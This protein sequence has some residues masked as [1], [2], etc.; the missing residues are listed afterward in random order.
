MKLL[1]KFLFF[2]SPLYYIVSFIRNLLYDTSLFKSTK[3]NL[4]VIGIGNLAIGGTGKSPMIEYLI[5]LLSQEFNIATLSRG[6]G[7]KTNTFK[8]ATKDSTHFDIGDEPLQFYNKHDNLIVSVDNNRVNGIQSLLQISNPPDVILLDD[9]YQHRKLIPGLSILLSD[10]SNLYYDDYI[11]PFGDLREPR[12]SSN[13]ADIVI[14]TK[15]PNNLSSSKK[16]EIKSKLQ[17]KVSQKLFFSSINYSETVIIGNKKV[18]FIN[19]ITQKFTL[20]TGLANSNHLVNY[21]SENKC[22]FNHLK[23][24]DHY[25]YKPKDLDNVDFNVNILTTEKDYAKL[26]EVFPEM[27]VYYLPIKVGIESKQEFDKI[28]LSYCR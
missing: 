4:P 20:V 11:L 6:Y 13:R 17:L 26:I 10:Y 9:S 12:S 19:F 7:R 3:F 21:L 16:L 1:R 23:F 27:N 5:H 2:I 18:E 24:K 22:D 25:N 8:I 15:C 14:V 28:I